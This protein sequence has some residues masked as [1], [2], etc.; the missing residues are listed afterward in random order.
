M[1]LADCIGIVALSLLATACTTSRATVVWKQPSDFPP[2]DRR[3]I[4]ELAKAVGFSDIEYVTTVEKPPSDDRDVLIASHS[5]WIGKKRTWS[6]L[7]VCD[8]RNSLLCTTREGTPLVQSGPWVTSAAHVD[9][10]ETWRVVDGSWFVDVRLGDG[11]E[12]SDASRIVMA[13]RSGA[14]VNRLRNESDTTDESRPEVF[15]IDASEI[16]SISKAAPP[17]VG[18]RVSVGEYVPQVFWIRLIDGTA[19]L[20]RYELYVI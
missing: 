9:T 8:S 16:S 7:L 18:F 1:T 12:F 19:E 2:D 15:T 14:L 20:Y 11:V 10:N 4:L 6:T 3:S 17:D 5:R 13:I